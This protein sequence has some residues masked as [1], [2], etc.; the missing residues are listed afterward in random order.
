MTRRT[1]IFDLGGVV[2]RWQPGALLLHHLPHRLPD[3]AAADALA[4][5]F[6]ES[7][8]PGSDW[9]EFDRGTLALHTVAERIARRLDL[10]PDEV[11]R[12]MQGVPAHLQLLEDSAGLLQQLHRA[13]HRLVFLSNMPADY[14]DHAQ[15]QIDRIGVFEEGV[16]SSMVGHVKPQ[17]DMFEHAQAAF[18]L[19]AADCLLL[20]DSAANVAAARQRGWQALLFT[21][22]AAARVDL[23]RLGLLQPVHVESSKAG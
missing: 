4:A 2:L 12:V 23:E 1:L 10:P 8:R 21:G 15:R 7:F 9:A 18:G 22:A 13:G 11:L 20:D 16:Y 19:A 6:F 5:R 17:D 14:R 3:R